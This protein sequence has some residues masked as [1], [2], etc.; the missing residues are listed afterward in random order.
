MAPH[1]SSLI[2]AL[3]AL[4]LLTPL[5]AAEPLPIDPLWRSETFRE[6]VTGSFGIDSRIEPRI[7]VDEEFYL[8]EAAEAMADEDRDLAIE[9]L[10]ESPLLEDSA[11]L[12]FNLATHLF[13]AGEREKAIERFEQALE[14]F[15]NFRDAHRN[16][17]IALVQDD[18][19][20][21]AQKHLVRAVELG[22]REGVTAG[23]LGYCHAMDDEHQAALDA[24]RLARLTQPEERQ[25][26]LGEAQALQAVGS[27]RRAASI[28]TEVLKESPADLPIWL[29][30]ADAWI[31]L[32]DSP[33]AIGNLELG[34][35]AGALGPPATLSLGHLY[36]RND[37]PALALSRYESA[38]ADSPTVPF[39]KAVEALELLVNVGEWAKAQQFGE[40]IDTH[41]AY[42]DLIGPSDRD[43]A[44]EETPDAADSRA[45]ARAKAENTDT[46]ETSDAA[47]VADADAL[48]ESAEDHREALS[49]YHRS[50][51]LIELEHGDPEKGA[52]LVESWLQREPLDGRA[53][54][55]LARFR[56]NAGDRERAE[57]LLERA[58][59]IPE[60]AASA[61][62][63]HGRLLVDAGEYEKAV[64]HLERAHELEPGE[65]L[66]DYLEAV[67]EL[68]E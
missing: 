28:Y 51:A 68:V 16:L 35:R 2:H 7:T 22:S 52:A 37:L 64:G 34:H 10:T 33:A 17:A 44:G 26:K 56:K 59:R 18:Q 66:A 19:L 40:R 61:H 47:A 11:A 5:A 31:A 8:E 32:D 58:E 30:Q 21:E 23:L 1:P 42:R 50:R 29:A 41:E 60:H 24:Y 67:R 53:L 20:E 63:A 6:T 25:W 54:V 55:L 48:E 4:A 15:P 45:A 12:L 36:L 13:Q 49:R 9:K 3:L 65:S 62:R 39:E 43:E 46:T 27:P 38:L 57:M 14:R